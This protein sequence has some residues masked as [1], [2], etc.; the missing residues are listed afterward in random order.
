[1]RPSAWR[2][3]TST[4]RISATLNNVNN[5]HPHE[6]YGYAVSFGVLVRIEGGHTV[7]VNAQWSRGAAGYGAATGTSF[8]ML[9]PGN[10]GTW[11]F[12]FDG[13]FDG[14]GSEVKLTTVWSVIG[15]AEYRWNPRWKTSWFAGYVGI[16]YSDG[17]KFLINPVAVCG[18][19]VG[20]PFGG[21]TLLPGNSC[22]PDWSFWQA[23]SRTQ[24]NPHPNL[25]IGLEIMYTRVNTAYAGPAIVNPGLPQNPV[26]RLD[27]IDFW[28]AF[29]RWQR[30]F[31]P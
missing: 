22:D 3:T 19:A 4:L 6:K 13:I 1:M 9:D 25:D 21:V 27:D 12:V 15:F 29:F 31:Y 17:A 10:F 14:R 2:R 24:W 5:G 7:G 26:F 8:S 18:G 16:E 28:S 30:N 11:G 20:V 23:G